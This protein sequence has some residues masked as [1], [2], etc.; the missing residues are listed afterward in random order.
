MDRF[1]SRAN[2]TLFRQISAGLGLILLA[3]CSRA[4]RI[5]PAVEIRTVDRVV[6]VQ[7]PCAVTIP[8]RPA[9]LQRPLPTDTTALAAILGAKLLE[10]MGPGGYVDRADA[11]LQSCTKP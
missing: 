8:A 3:G 10:L 11:A 4:N 1:P 5:P 2:R 9:K 6:E 7:R